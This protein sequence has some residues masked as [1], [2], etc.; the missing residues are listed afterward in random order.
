MHTLWT[1]LAVIGATAVMVL[2]KWARSAS[3]NRFWLRR[4]QRH[5]K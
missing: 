2:S 5:K 1:V 3:A 4:Q